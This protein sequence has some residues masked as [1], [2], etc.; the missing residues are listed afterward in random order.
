MHE[1]APETWFASA[2]P[3]SEHNSEAFA[4]THERDVLLVFDEASK[5]ADV[6][7]KY[8]RGR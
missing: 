5:I 6:I 7:G 2:I 4:G 1:A 8:P 3:W